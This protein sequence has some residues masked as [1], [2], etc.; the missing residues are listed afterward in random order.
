MNPQIKVTK[1]KYGP[2]EAALQILN[3][4]S[5]LEKDL[6]NLND[7]PLS[8]SG[9]QGCSPLFRYAEV[10]PPLSSV[11]VPDEVNVVDGKTHH[12]FPTDLNVE[13]V[14][15]YVAPIEAVLQ[16]STSGKWPDDLEALRMTKAAF[17][18]QIADNLRDQK[19]LRVH[20]SQQHIDIMKVS[21]QIISQLLKR[22]IFT[23]ES[24]SGRFG[25]PIQNSSSKRN[26]SRQTASRR[27]RCDKV[28]R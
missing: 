9:V 12:L 27:R 6:T 18:I 23:N 16:L 20:A 14:P 7:L 19:N 2:E 25:F 4:F 22:M 15:T 24:F 26:R 21:F 5:N 8:I 17:H 10:F 28:S 3:V 13:E 1:F 11:H